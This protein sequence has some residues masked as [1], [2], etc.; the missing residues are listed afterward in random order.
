MVA[1]VQGLSSE[2]FLLLFDGTQHMISTD[3][4]FE[5]F[6]SGLKRP[7]SRT[8]P[9]FWL[10]N[11]TWLAQRPQQLSTTVGHLASVPQNSAH[12]QTHGTHYLIMQYSSAN[13]PQTLEEV[14]AVFQKVSAGRF[15]VTGVFTTVQPEADSTSQ[16]SLS[17]AIAKHGGLPYLLVEFKVDVASVTLEA[18]ALAAAQT[19]PISGQQADLAPRT[20]PKKRPADSNVQPAAAKKQQPSP[21]RP[22]AAAAAVSRRQLSGTD[23][24]DADQPATQVASKQHHQAAGLAPAASSAG[25]AVTTPPSSPQ[26][27][28]VCLVQDGT[29]LLSKGLLAWQFWC[30][31]QLYVHKYALHSAAFGSKVVMCFAPCS[32][33]C[34]CSVVQASNKK[35]KATPKGTCEARINLIVRVLAHSRR[36]M[37]RQEIIRWHS[38]YRTCSFAC[39]KTD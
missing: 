39:M 33:A 16:G 2:R 15:G 32:Y 27:S 13:A 8:Q 29:A 4:G 20:S 6:K 31:C 25:E 23:K 35:V 36:R 14:Q 7:D 11:D 17:S 12:M 26:V 37:L 3:A 10:S 24:A 18:G 19:A 21:V 22:Q 30:C 28:C 9:I 1:S 38:Q 5:P 34:G